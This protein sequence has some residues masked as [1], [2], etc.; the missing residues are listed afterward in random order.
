MT[1]VIM[2][3]EIITPKIVTSVRLLFCFRCRMVN[4]LTIFIALSPVFG[5]PPIFNRNDS[6][7]LQGDPFVMRDYDQ[8]L[9]IGLIQHFQ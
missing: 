2:D 9:M 3:T 7:G 1:A 8:C 4:V 5:N 6:V